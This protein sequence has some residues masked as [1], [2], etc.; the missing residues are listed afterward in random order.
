MP[1]GLSGVEQ[2]LDPVVAEVRDPQRDAL[3]PLDEVVYSLGRPA[4][5]MG[6][7]SGGGLVSPSND[8]AAELT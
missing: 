5:H 2:S 6:E 1:V 8:G 7:V 3:H 4:G